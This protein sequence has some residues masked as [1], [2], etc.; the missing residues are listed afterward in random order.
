MKCNLSLALILLLFTV[1][2]CEKER[3][4]EDSKATNTS[5]GSLQ[6]DAGECLPKLVNGNFVAGVTLG[7]THSIEVDVTVD[8][9]GS[10][11]ITTDTLNGYYFSA[12]GEFTTT[13]LNAV[14]LTGKGKPL[15]EGGD[16]FTVTY[17]S[18]SCTVDVNVLPTSGSVPAVFTLQTNGA[19]CMDAVINGTYTKGVALN[20]TNKVDIKVN[21]VTI[22]SYAVAATATNGMNFSGSGSFNAT[23]I[24]TITL[25]GSGTPVNDGSIAVPVAVGNSNCSFTVPVVVGTTNPPTSTYKWKFTS[26]SDVHQGPVDDDALL[27]VIPINAS[28]NITSLTFFGSTVAGDTSVLLAIADLNNLITANETYLTSA[29]T[30]NS[31]AIEIDYNGAIYEANPTITGVAVT[32]KVTSHN[33]TTKVVSGT[34]SGTLK[35]AANNQTITITNGEFTV[36]YQ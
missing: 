24:Q 7:A 17:D 30:T 12:T 4:L 28:V 2:S 16:I 18:T 20:S 1:L 25:T 22:G 11:F 10:Y 36:H 27:E 33:T 34:F 32:I 13:G 5:Q 15:A 8:E 26:G 14:T 3:S 9:V 6:S 23:G 31:G 21:V 35:N 29:T 19:T